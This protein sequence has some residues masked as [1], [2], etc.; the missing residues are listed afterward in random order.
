MTKRLLFCL[1]ALLPVSAWAEYLGEYSIADT[2][3]I[4]F[5]TFDSNGGSVTLTGLA[6]TD[7][8]VYKNGSMTQRSSDAGYT[9]TDTDGIDLDGAA[10]VHGFS[11][12]LSDNTDAGFWSAGAQY[13]VV[14]N[15]VTIDGQT[16]R[17]VWK[18]QTTADAWQDL[19]DGT[20][21][22]ADDKDMGQAY[23]GTI[24]GAP[25][26]QTI[27]DIATTD[28]A[29][30]ADAYNQA[31]AW[32]QGGTEHCFRRITDY[33]GNTNFRITI[34]SA[35]DFTIASADEVRIRWTWGDLLADL[36]TALA[37]DGMV[38][39]ASQG[40]VDLLSD[41]TALHDAIVLATGT[42][43]SGSTTTCRDAAR[44]E[45]ENFWRYSAIVFQSGSNDNVGR[46][47]DTFAAATD[48]L[49]F[50]D[51]PAAV[52]TEQ[53]KLIFAPECYAATQTG[54]AG[55]G[56][57][58][59]GGDGDHLTESGGTGDQFTA[60]PYNSAWDADIQSEA[61]DA[62]VANHLD[63]LL[64]ADY[65]PA[66]KPGTSTALLNE[67]IESDSGVSRYTANALEQGPS[68]AGSGDITSI[69][70]DT[71]A[72]DNLEALL[73]G[74][75]G[76]AFSDNAIT[77]GTLAAD[78]IGASEVASDAIG[79]SEIATNA[80]DADSLAADVGT[81]IW[82]AECED[83]GTVNS[84][85]DMLQLIGSTLIGVC[86]YDGASTYTC[87]DPGG[88]ETRIVFTYGSDAGDRTNV[89]ATP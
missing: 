34:E 71:T 36:D 14:V 50:V 89:V 32:I 61:N 59:A 12:D 42:C 56:L 79:A 9:L 19:K 69:S 3:Y 1:L 68:G 38:L 39:S 17:P 15:S 63:H 74:T 48:D 41:V 7:I 37:A 4:D 11:L 86:D 16:V 23:E 76:V 46:C 45:A 78:S 13:T 2:V 70:G 87:Q 44:T 25:T 58:E 43:D 64:A 77:A 84:C 81:E 85:K 5:A 49:G 80:I 40:N 55:A 60:V 75:G 57:T 18:F 22:L 26:S 27:F 51:T 33:D 31:I 62:L 24:D 88:N 20:V 8:E 83:Q 52:S 28:A 47:V 21:E 66:S 67:L 82:A 10:G 65:D 29:T 53:Y 30:N 54:A 72:A 6:V 73:D 35:C